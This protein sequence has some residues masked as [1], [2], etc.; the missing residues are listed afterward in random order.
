MKRIILI[1]LALVPFGLFANNNADT[2]FW[3]RGGSYSISFT[4]VSLSN[5]AAG[6]QSS[7]SGVTQLKMFANYK[8]ANISW[9]NKFDLGY[10]LSYIKDMELQ[11][12]EDII[13]MQSKL[14][15]QSSNKWY[16]TVLGSFKTQLSPGYS[17]KANTAKA[18]N[19]FAPAYLNLSV[20]MD[21][22]PNDKFTL[23]LSPLSGKMT[24]VTDKDLDGKFG[25]DQG[26]TSRM[27]LGA[28]MRSN[29]KTQVVKNVNLDTDLGLF[30]NYLKNPEKVDVD[31]K[32]G[33][34]MGIN[35]FL[36]VRLHTH[37][38]YDYDVKF[39]VKNSTTGETKD[40]VQFKEIL[41]IGLNFTF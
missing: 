17:D 41:G 28:S 35:K 37:L 18:S 22:K 7:V 29:F 39:P 25:V 2:T 31:W 36:S 23:F 38:I 16:Y 33:I 6:G 21:Y 27:E 13:D 19:L 20:G 14:G 34:V 24:I 12:I 1:A 26:K 5:W 15:I 32:L 11:K 4:Q 9:D 30:A 10:G 8:K 3:K 40:M